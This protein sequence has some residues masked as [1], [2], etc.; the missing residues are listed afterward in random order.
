MPNESTFESLFSHPNRLVIA[1]LLLLGALA[2]LQLING[3]EASAL[4]MHHA[5]SGHIVG[6]V[7]TTE[8]RNLGMLVLMRLLMAV[9]MMLP[10]A[11]PAILSFA[12]V[13][14]AGHQ[15]HWAPGRV[16]AFVGGYLCTWS[17]FGVLAATM[18]WGFASA[19]L[20]FPLI[21]GQRPLL[22]GAVLVVAGLYQFSALKEVCLAQCRSPLGFFLAH[23]RDGVRGAIYLGSRHG[24]HCVGCCWAL[25]S[26]MLLAGGMSITWTVVLSVV[27][28]IEKIAPVGRT[29]VRALGIAL[30]V[31]GS[32]VVAS[33]LLR[34]VLT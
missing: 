10:A 19:T 24:I 15:K 20:R 14:F 18:Q 17:G 8:L 21:D 6:N 11:A 25:M 5:H 26:L 32:V 16:V 30:I 22:G 1:T 28:L 3:G 23:W 9:A 34:R 4:G 31:V 33:D 7:A 29:V 12:D 2:W 13:A 27:M